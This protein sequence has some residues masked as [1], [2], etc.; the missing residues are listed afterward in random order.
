MIEK[1]THKF[2]NENI[3]QKK[4]MQLDKD[5]KKIVRKAIVEV[6][7]FNGDSAILARVSV[8]LQNPPITI[9]AFTVREN[10]GHKYVLPPS[11]ISYSNKMKPTIW[12]PLELFYMLNM[13][14]LETYEKTL[15]DVG[16]NKQK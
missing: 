7:L 11:Y 13:K 4:R 12:M 1:I 5:Y 16:S 14:I 9:K 2:M 8:D 3:K 6:K 10:D 15:R